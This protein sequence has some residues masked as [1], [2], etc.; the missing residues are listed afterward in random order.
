MAWAGGDGIVVIV[1]LEL[2]GVVSIQL[3]PRLLP[4]LRL[5]LHARRVRI[6]LG[7]AQGAA[8]SPQESG[9][10]ACEE[11]PGGACG[12]ADD[13]A[14]ELAVHP[15]ELVREAVGVVAAVEE[16]DREVAA[17]GGNANDSC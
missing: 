16:L 7:G 12:G 17:V 8:Q 3:H 5:E 2:D 10:V 14:G 13:A 15:R 4:P 6:V 9:Y 1:G 11:R